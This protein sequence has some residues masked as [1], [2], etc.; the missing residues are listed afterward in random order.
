M[1]TRNPHAWTYN[2]PAALMLLAPFN[3]LASLGM[4]IYLPVVPAMPGILG[5]TP[6]V[7]QLTLTLYMIVL[8]V[9]QLLFGPLSDRLG[10]RP[11]LLAGALIFAIASLALAATSSGV[12]FLALRLLQAIGAS[13][14]LVALFATIRDVYAEKPES[15]V[16]YSLMNAMLAFVPALGPIAGAVIAQEF[17]WRGVFLALGIPAL[18]MLPIVLS[19]WHETRVLRPGAHGTAF[20]PIL[21]NPAFR[22][23]TLGFGT[24]MGSFFVFFS[25]APRV[26]MENAGFSGLEFSLA[27]ATVAAAMIVTTR[28]AK[29]L[30]KRWGIGGSAL[31]GMVLLIC[32]AVLLFLGQICLG[33]SFWSFIPPMWVCAAGIVVTTSVTANGALRDFHDAAGSAV[34]LHFCLQSIIVG[35]AGTAFVVMLDGDT[36]W[37]LIAY[38]FSMAS[39]TVLA[40][41]RVKASVPGLRRA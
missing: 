3:L 41:L 20:G 26:L 32:G 11:V 13:A 2:L 33:P 40:L 27:F 38:T 8:G 16:I 14:M 28:F 23:Y 1:P 30:V 9:G 31:R 4:D 18:A 6:T 21:K 22:A 35:V 24:A 29:Q 37:P 15:V 10:R 34:A 39:V 25:T 36:G 7:I 17:G 12:P 5:T 19:C